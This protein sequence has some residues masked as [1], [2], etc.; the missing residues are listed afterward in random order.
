MIY[1][2]KFNAFGI[3]Y[4]FVL[5]TD[6]IE[7]N[8]EDES[9]GYW[10]VE[11][12]GHH[13]EVNIWKE[14]GSFSDNGKVY[15]FKDYG[16]FVDAGAA[17]EEHDIEFSIATRFDRAVLFLMD[18][19][20]AQDIGDEWQRIEI[21]RCPPSYEMQD[22]IMDLLD[23]FSDDNDYPRDWWEEMYDFEDFFDAL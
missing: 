3:E 2:T 20:P 15:C 7:R 14:N 1:K 8:H 9:Y 17:D 11:K 22:R 21:E 6:D 16:N 13:F 18:R 23:E 5:D 4:Q 12:D 10:I 19:I